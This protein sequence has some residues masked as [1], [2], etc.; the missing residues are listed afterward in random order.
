MIKMADDQMPVSKIDKPMQERYRIAA[1]GHANQVTPGRRKLG[2]DVR[3]ES[4]FLFR[5]R[6]HAVQQATG[7]ESRQDIKEQPQLRGPSPYLLPQ[8]EGTDYTESRVSRL[9]ALT[10]SRVWPRRRQRVDT[11]TSGG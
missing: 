1:A 3:I 4:E 2:D 8:G 10:T 7:A 9:N 11:S 5:R 6:L